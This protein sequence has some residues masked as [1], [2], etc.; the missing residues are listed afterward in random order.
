MVS[1]P[2]RSRFSGGV[3]RLEFYSNE[4]I[5]QIIE[6]SSKLL[7]TELE[8]AIQD[9]TLLI[10]IML[11][12]NE[13]GTIQPIQKIGNW[14]NKLNQERTQNNLTKIYLHTD[15]CQAAGS[16]DL[17]V[18]KLHV[19][20]LTLNGSKIYGPKGIGV[21]Y[22]KSGT[23]LVPLIDGGGQERNLRSGT[24]NIPAII[25]LAKALSLAQNS[26]EKENERLTALRDYLIK[27]LLTKIPKTI[28]NG[29]AQERLANNVNISFLDVEGEALLLYLDEAGIQAST[30]SACTSTT[31][32]PSHVIRALGRPYEAAHGSLRFTLGKH[33]T[34]K[35]LEYLI[36]KLAIIVDKL[37]KA[38]PVIVDM[39]ELERAIKEAPKK[40]INL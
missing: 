39:A 8:K 36:E 25:G 29:H 38:S 22:I 16:L 15:A 3:F 21:L 35:D 40:I 7:K 34:K 12:N 11:A 9:N 5:A 33:T 24:E 27:E 26:K 6:R 13:V 32:E 28:L 4:E 20:L 23:N 37:R 1:S 18:N 31:L 17:D 14:L 30:G 10:S 19:D 2:L